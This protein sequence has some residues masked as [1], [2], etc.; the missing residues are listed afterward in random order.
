MIYITKKHLT[1]E[2]RITIE[3]ELKDPE[4]KLINIAKIIGKDPRTVSKEIKRNRLFV[5]NQYRR[6]KLNS[7]TACYQKPC[8]T[9][10]RFPY[11]C[12]GCKKNCTR[13]H[14]RY[15]GRDA[16]EKYNNYYLLLERV[17]IYHLTKNHC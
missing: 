11:V 15:D 5:D 1:I 2:E 4:C 3:K 9:L 14:Y 13:D 17:M 16:H 7:T 10:L 12:N 8:E 6:K